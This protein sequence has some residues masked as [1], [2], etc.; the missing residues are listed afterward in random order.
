MLCSPAHRADVSRERHY[1]L[2]TS[3]ACVG[4][5]TYYSQASAI[6]PLKSGCS[7]LSQMFAVRIQRNNVSKGFLQFLMHNK[8]L[9]PFL[10]IFLVSAYMY[11]ELF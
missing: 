2:W 1:S 10:S 11:H 5:A 7:Y 9:I 4:P 8:Y 3:S 6:S